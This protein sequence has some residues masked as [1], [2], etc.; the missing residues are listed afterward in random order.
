MNIHLML[1]DAIR[2]F[3]ACRQPPHA[4]EKRTYVFILVP[5]DLRGN[6]HAKKSELEQDLIDNG[7]RVGGARTGAF[8]STLTTLDRG[9]TGA[10][11][12]EDPKQRSGT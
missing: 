3:A 8:F 1:T 11:P 12:D 2:R 4:V 9:A 6:G 5:F 10:V 7:R